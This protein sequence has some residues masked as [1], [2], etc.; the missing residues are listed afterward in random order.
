MKSHTDEGKG[1]VCLSISAFVNLYTSLY[2]MSVCPFGISRI[3][4]TR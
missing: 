1:R 4:E 3:G 2:C